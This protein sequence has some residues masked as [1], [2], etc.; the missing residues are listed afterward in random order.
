ME[1]ASPFEELNLKYNASDE[2]DIKEINKLL[3]EMLSYP[4]TEIADLHWAANRLGKAD[5]R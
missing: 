3:Y 4:S 5:I 2:E 1:L